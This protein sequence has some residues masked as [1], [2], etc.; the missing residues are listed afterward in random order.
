ML[1]CDRYAAEVR[2]DEAR[3]RELGISGVPFFVIGG[4]LGVSG[5]QPPDVLLGALERGW[6]EMPAG[7]IADGAACGPDGC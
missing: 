3:A 2:A 4:R 5:A 6:A 1:A 7:E